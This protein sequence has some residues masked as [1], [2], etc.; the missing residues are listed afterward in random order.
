MLPARRFEPAPL[1]EIACVSWPVLRTNLGKT[2]AGLLK[3]GL[4]AQFHAQCLVCTAIP[5]EK[6]LEKAAYRGD[7]H[8]KEEFSGPIPA[9]AAVAGAA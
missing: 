1:G 3:I 2:S 7:Y 6:S 4:L 8:P 9:P 5:T